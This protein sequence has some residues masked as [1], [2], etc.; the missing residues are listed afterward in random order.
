MT[1]VIPAAPEESDEDG[2]AAALAGVVPPWPRIG[3]MAPPTGP[4]GRRGAA[5]RGGQGRWVA[6]WPKA[7]LTV[8]RNSLRPAPMLEPPPPSL[9]ARRMG[10]MSTAARG[11]RG[12]GSRQLPRCFVPPPPGPAITTRRIPEDSV[13][14]TMRLVSRGGKRQPW[15]S[16][17]SDCTLS[18]VI[19]ALPAAE[20]PQFFSH[21]ARS[22]NRHP[23][24]RG[25]AHVVDGERGDRRGGE[26][27]HLDAGA[28][29]RVDL[30]L[31]LDVGL[32][33]AEVDE[34]APHQGGWQRGMRFEVCLAAWM[35]ATRAT[36]RT[37]PL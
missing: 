13:A 9:R 24:I 21:R 19:W 12:R 1:S 30:G 25:L 36:A 26:R 31:D 34:D 18:V 8:V 3:P 14:V 11:S 7:E 29:H 33:E 5:C 22:P 37:S 2:A 20:R 27:L 10:G 15:W 35:P 32:L 4:T 6:V 23:A 16:K 28:V 17:T